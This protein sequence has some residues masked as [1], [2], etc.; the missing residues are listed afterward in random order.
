MK[1]R[2][3]KNVYDLI[4]PAALRPQLADVPRRT[5]SP[6]APNHL[7]EPECQIWKRTFSEYYLA[8]DLAVDDLRTAL[9]AH[10]RAREAREAIERDG[11]TVVGRDNQM[12]PHPL[13]A[14]ERDARAQWL[15]AIKQLGIEL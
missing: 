4:E 5:R 1:H 11:M 9:E 3:R 14:V 8:T 12:K 2:G 7:G 6:P 10:Q 15:A 13:L